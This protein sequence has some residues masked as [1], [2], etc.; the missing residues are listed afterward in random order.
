MYAIQGSGKCEL[1]SWHFGLCF[2][3]SLARRDWW[4]GLTSGHLH[5]KSCTVTALSFAQFFLLL[6]AT[7]QNVNPELYYWAMYELYFS[8]VMF[9]C[10]R[11]WSR[12]SGCGSLLEKVSSFFQHCHQHSIVFKLH[13]GVPWLILPFNYDHIIYGGPVA[14][15]GYI[16]LRSSPVSLVFMQL[17][18]KSEAALCVVCTAPQSSLFHR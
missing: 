6:I 14:W 18:V 17:T 1:I 15:P 5:E 11:I 10:S 8:G 12:I 4:L 16:Y 7:A 9:S 3:S 2:L 13:H